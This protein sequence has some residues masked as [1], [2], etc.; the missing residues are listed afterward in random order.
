[1]RLHRYVVSPSLFTVEK[2][3]NTC[4][5]LGCVAAG[6]GA[7]IPTVQRF[8]LSLSWQIIIHLRNIRWW[9]RQNVFWNFDLF[10][11]DHLTHSAE[12]SST[13]SHRCENVSSEF[14]SIFSLIYLFSYIFFVVLWFIQ[15]V[16]RKIRLE[17]LT[18]LYVNSKIPA[19]KEPWT[20]DQVTSSNNLFPLNIVRILFQIQN[21]VIVEKTFR[22]FS[23]DPS[24]FRDIWPQA[25]SFKYIQFCYQIL[26][27][28]LCSKFINQGPSSEA[29]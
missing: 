10:L 13:Y 6:S 14:I 24:N 18:D 9:W 23:V 21:P 12:G 27:L 26:I 19:V 1:M 4:C 8:M 5:L 16:H 17:K 2:E 29:N 22:F 15:A 7:K 3:F 11:A 20:S 28:T 25:L